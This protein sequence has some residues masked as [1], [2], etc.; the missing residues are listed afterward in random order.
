MRIIDMKQKTKSTLAESFILLVSGAVFG[1][2]V[3]VLA[4]P[5]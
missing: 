2:V 3:V 5:V 4:I 1:A